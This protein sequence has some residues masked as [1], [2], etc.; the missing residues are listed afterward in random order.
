MVTSIYFTDQKMVVQAVF[1]E[2]II[3]YVDLIKAP[4]ILF[5]DIGILYVDRIAAPPYYYLYRD[6]MCGPYS[7]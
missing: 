1:N 3:D 6:I 5:I 2:S 4:P 7:S